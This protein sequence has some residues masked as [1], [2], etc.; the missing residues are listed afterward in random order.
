MKSITCAITNIIYGSSDYSFELNGELI[1]IFSDAK[2]YLTRGKN[3]QLHHKINAKVTS[4]KL[5]DLRGC[6]NEVMVLTKIKRRQLS[7][8]SQVP[9]RSCKAVGKKKSDYTSSHCFPCSLKQLFCYFLE[10]SSKDT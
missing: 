1:K 8:N 5:D 7:E 6:L 10:V 2:H 3:V 4:S 9:H